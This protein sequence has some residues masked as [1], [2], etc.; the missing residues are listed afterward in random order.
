MADL[1]EECTRFYREKI[2][3][4]GSIPKE[5]RSL[6]SEPWELPGSWNRHYVPERFLDVSCPLRP[7][8]TLLL[9]D[10]AV[11]PN[12]AIIAEAFK[13]LMKKDPS[14]SL[15][16]LGCL[17]LIRFGID[18][19][20]FGLSMALCEVEDGCRRVLRYVRLKD[21]SCWG[22]PRTIL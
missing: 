10:A 15:G 5:H 14:V 1:C 11:C 8:G 20:D 17:Q 22:R 4:V 9:L 2:V 7:L 6:A 21:I 16:A 12:C 3:R 19:Q 18:Q 13:G